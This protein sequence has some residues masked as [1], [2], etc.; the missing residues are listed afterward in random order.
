MTNLP[1][2]L[3]NKRQNNVLV[4]WLLLLGAVVALLQIYFVLRSQLLPG[5]LGV[6]FTN[7]GMAGVFSRS[8]RLFLL[9][10]ALFPARFLHWKHRIY[11]YAARSLQ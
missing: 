3:E 5:E 2:L 10:Y 9:I 7:S 6:I 1:L 11:H 8:P 4:C